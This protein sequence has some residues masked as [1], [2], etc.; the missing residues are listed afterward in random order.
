LVQP[1]PLSAWHTGT[2]TVSFS[3]PGSTS[4]NATIA[5]IDLEIVPASTPPPTTTT[6]PPTTTTIPATT[7]TT[8]VSGRDLWAG[9]APPQVS[10]DFNNPANNFGFG[11]IVADPTVPGVVF[12]GTCY[13]GLWKSTDQGGTWTKINTGVGGGLL[14]QGRL[15]TLAI[16]PFNHN[17]LWTTSGYGPGGPLKSTDGG[18]SWTLLPVGSPTQYNDVYSIRLDPYLPDHVLMAWHSP[19]STDANSGVTESTDGGQTWINHPAPAGSNWGA[20]NAVWFLSNSHTWLLGSQNGGI[21]RT[22]DSGTTWTPVRSENIT[23]GGNNSL[24]TVSGTLYLAD[25]T[26]IET[27]TDDGMT[28]TDITSGLPYAYY[29]TVVTDGTNIYTAPAFPM[30]SYLNGPWYYRPLSGGHPWQP[31]NTQPTCDTGNCNGPVMS[32]YD[33]TNHT[34][35]AVNF[36]GGVWKHADGG[37]GW[38]RSR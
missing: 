26:N 7:T 22:A 28:W 4:Q 27:S 12:V 16:D 13:Q 33:P 5:N 10:T 38:D 32:G 11:S 30:A 2:N 31:Y 29:E 20:G 35:Y 18:V 15:W 37:A 19:W 34:G 36:L 6:V 23:H 3:D 14:D 9:I 21:S 8:V 17:T 1:I 25:S 24:V